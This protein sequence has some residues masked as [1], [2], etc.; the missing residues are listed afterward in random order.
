MHTSASYTTACIHVHV[1][2]NVVY[3]TD[4]IY[5]QHYQPSLSTSITRAISFLSTVVCIFPKKAATTQCVTLALPINAIPLISRLSESSTVCIFPKK[6]A[7][8]QC[9]TL[10]LPINAIP[11]ISRLSES[12]T[13][14]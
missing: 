3:C 6:A 13:V 8:T 1:H 10:A 9:V 14:A 7:T 2:T 4:G 5:A 12:S 11:L